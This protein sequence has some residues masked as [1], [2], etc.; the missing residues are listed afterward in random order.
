MSNSTRFNFLGS[1]DFSLFC[2]IPHKKDKIIY[3]SS[4]KLLIFC[5]IYFLKVIVIQIHTITLLSW[6]FILTRA[7][8]S[9]VSR[10]CLLHKPWVSHATPL[11]HIHKF[12]TLC[13]INQ[14]A[15]QSHTH[16]SSFIILPPSEDKGHRL[17][18]G[19][20]WQGILR[21]S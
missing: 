14:R 3:K 9:S 4:L 11:P 2:G 10:M 8:K 1:L 6:S 21:T 17:C 5:Q 7:E 18:S 13:A 16:C 15:G 19:L 12:A 20:K